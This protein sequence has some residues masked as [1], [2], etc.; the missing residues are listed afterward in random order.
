MD[1]A[2]SIHLVCART[3]AA[4][5]STRRLFEAYQKSLGIDL[6]FQGFEQ[7]LAN[8]P[9]DYAPPG[10]DL[11]MALVDGKPAGCCAFR[12]LHTADY[13]NA[14]EMK[15]LYVQPAF[16]GLGLGRLLAE[17]TLDLARQAGYAAM[18][19]DTL[20][21]MEAARSLY[22]ELGFVE[23]PPYYHNPLPGAHYLKVS[24]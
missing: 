7:E 19:L 21:D 22:Q 15:R 9:G 4:Y 24:L 10:G 13:P 14:C 3:T 17:R 1:D 11:L 5:A 8:L 23:V 12:P 6:C 18:L 2:P 20:S 16:R